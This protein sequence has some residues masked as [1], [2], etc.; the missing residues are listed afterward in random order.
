MPVI[1][2]PNH[3]YLSRTPELPY[4]T[5]DEVT[6]RGPVGIILKPKY[7]TLLKEKLAP[8]GIT[9]GPNT[10]VLPNVQ[11]PQNFMV[12][13]NGNH[14]G[15]I[16]LT[17]TT[18]EQ[19]GSYFRLNS[20]VHRTGRQS[21]PSNPKAIQMRPVGKAVDE[22]AQEMSEMIKKEKLGNVLTNKASVTALKD[23]TGNVDTA[24]N[25]GTMTGIV[26][27]VKGVDIG[28]GRKRKTRKL[29]SRKQKKTR[30]H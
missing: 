11:R 15:W 16:G 21:N 10:I 28:Q 5:Q 12:Y 18:G 23:T 1:R 24:R 27:N 3:D 19:P 17:D 13:K 6:T 29:R 2:S 4:F 25:I 22:F 14:I 20:L 8:L 26:P 7:E 30:K 9:L